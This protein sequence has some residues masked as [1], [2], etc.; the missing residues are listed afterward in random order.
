MVPFPLVN[1]T[2]MAFSYRATSE[3]WSF[4][5]TWWRGRQA[6][7]KSIPGGFSVRPG[8]CCTQAGRQTRQERLNTVIISELLPAQPCLFAAGQNQ[9]TCNWAQHPRPTSLSPSLECLKFIPSCQI[10]MIAGGWSWRRRSR[11]SRSWTSRR[12]KLRRRR[13]RL[14]RSRKYQN[15]YEYQSF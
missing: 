13:Q 11:R 9:P 12:N 14:R 5:P 2:V 6:D 10:L 15:L 4:L 8:C 1:L 7:R 3:G